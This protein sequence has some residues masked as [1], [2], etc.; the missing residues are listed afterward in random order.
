[1]VFS[2]DEF[3]PLDL[4]PHPGWQR[5]ERG[6]RYANPHRQPRPQLRATYSA[7]TGAAPVRALDLGRN[8]LY[9]HVKRRKERAQFLE[10][11]RY[12]RALYPPDVPIAIVCDNYSPHLSTLADTSIGDWAATGRA[13]RP[14]R[15]PA[16]AG[17][18]RQALMPARWSRRAES[19]PNC[20]CMRCSLGRK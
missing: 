8:V 5:T 16:G 14:V 4:Q 13:C 19:T 10:F 2:V 1:V 15:A 6:G 7:R 9:G 17:G 3:G 20:R 18:R 11:C 12:L